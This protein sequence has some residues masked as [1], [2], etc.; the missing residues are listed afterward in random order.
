MHH[1]N[2]VVKGN[3]LHMWS[4]IKNNVQV[5]NL[6]KVS[7]PNFDIYL[8]QASILYVVLL[9]AFSTSYTTLVVG[10]DWKLMSLFSN[11]K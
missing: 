7:G 1:G 10:P 4:E 6:C 11:D 2:L 9:W 5:Q 3:L 8:N